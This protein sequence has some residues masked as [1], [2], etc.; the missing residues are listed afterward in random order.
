MGNELTNINMLGAESYTDSQYAELEKVRLFENSWMAIAFGSDVAS[1][2]QSLPCSAL[3][4]PILITRDENNEL[5]VF[6]NVC[7]HRG[8]ILNEHACVGKKL[9]T[10]PYHSW[11]Y[12]LNGQLIKAPYWD[13]TQDSS[14]NKT[15]IQS[16]ALRP[17]RFAVWYD[18][19]FINISGNAPSFENFIAP[20]DQR[21]RRQ[22]P[23]S[24]LRSFTKKDYRIQGNWKLAAENFLDN[25][26]LPWVHPEV[27]SSIEASLGTD[28]E[29]LSL[30]QH[31][32]GF[33]H[34][35]AGKDKSKTDK[36]LPG[37]PG[38]DPLEFMRQDLIFIFPNMCF[39]MEGNYLWSMILL[40]DG[41]HR[42]AEKLALYV[43]GETAM[44]GQYANSRKQLEETIYRINDQDATVIRGLQIGRNSDT[45]SHGIFNAHHDQLGIW[46]HQRISSMLECS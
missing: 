11:S 28:V 19:I 15:Q 40:P 7:R 29:N 41:T 25:Y 34:P 31:I 5:H 38:I 22:Y 20:L 45:A 16:M 17:I 8:H 33:T 10:C 9:L 39:V 42:C 4:H 2:N 23:E 37:W 30:A 12:A 35:T 27:G 14:P 21:W 6:S 26:H 43:A 18:T 44:T 46:F 24:Q 32:I 13:G 36:V 1:P 3:G